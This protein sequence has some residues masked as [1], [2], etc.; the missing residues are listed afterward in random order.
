MFWYALAWCGAAAALTGAG[1]VYAQTDPVKRSESE[2]AAT[3]SAALPSHSDQHPLEPFGATAHT[4]TAPNDG[5]T[6]LLR[7]LQGHTACTVSLDDDFAW[8]ATVFPAPTAETS[9][10]GSPMMAD[11]AVQWA[12]FSMPHASHT[13]LCTAED[14]TAVNTFVPTPNAGVLAASALGV[15]SLGAVR[16]RRA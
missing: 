15:L 7:G 5:F 13:D 8:A 1:S 2:C 6:R 16:R 12:P 3:I 14:S 11:H 9:S 10:N 4:Q